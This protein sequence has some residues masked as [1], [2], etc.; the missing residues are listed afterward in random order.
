VQPRKRKDLLSLFISPLMVKFVLLWSLVPLVTDA[1]ELKRTGF[2]FLNV[3]PSARIAALGGVNVSLV[4]RDPSGFFFSPALNGDSLTGF[5][6]ASYQFYVADIGH[7]SFSYAPSFKKLGTITLGVQHFG[8]GTIKGYDASGNELGD[9][10]A[11]ETAIVVSKSHQIGPYRI[12]VSMKPVFSSLAGY[13]STALLFDFGGVFVH[14]R[15]EIRVGLAVKNL[16]FLLSDY[17]PTSNSMLPVDVQL[18]TTFKPEHM[19]FRF[20]VTLYR[21][22]QS[23]TVNYIS[24]AQES[25]SALDKVFRHFNFGTEVLFHRNVNLLVGYNYGIH[26]ELRLENGGGAAGITFGF[27]ARVKKME[28]VFSRSTYVT[29]SPAYSFTLNADLKRM[30]KRS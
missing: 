6:S 7:A 8:Y 24:G 25:A 11:S 21:L 5:A 9:F 30:L 18:G 26:R 15:K 29:R 28:L 19:P 22:I 1:Q 27:S 16:G 3:P 12:G 20:S 23:E 10:N 4:D 13:R 14:P 2:R 17:S